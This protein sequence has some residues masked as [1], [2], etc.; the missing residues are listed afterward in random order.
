M[1][2]IPDLPPALAGEG[3]GR[4]S[5]L[6]RYEDITQDGRVILTALMPGLGPSAWRAMLAANPRA[7]AAMRSQGILP[8][9]RRL[10]LVG[11]PGPF[12]V[13]VAI[14]YEGHWRVARE[15]GGDRLFLVMWLE[16]YAPHASTLGPAPPDDAPRAL[17]GRVFAEHVMTRPF[18]PKEQRRVTRLELPG[19]PELP[20]REHV[21]E[22]VDALV[23]GAPLDDAG[24]VAF[25]MTHTD[26]NQ[27]VNSLVYPRL[28]EQAGVGRSKRPELLARRAEMRWRKPFFAGDVAR[29]RL[30]VEGTRAVGTF[31]SADATKPNAAVALALG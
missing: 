16:A 8:I 27:H 10:V 25:G 18:G 12:S 15:K 28:F 31:A 9:L 3:S 19:L 5:L 4:A 23:A 26:S 7:T 20:D 11:E 24:D 22:D 17:V 13:G 30:H 2:E 6:P 14:E 1:M 29:L 21:F